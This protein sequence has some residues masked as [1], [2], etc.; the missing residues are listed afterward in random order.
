MK[1]LL[2]L[3]DFV[4]RYAVEILGLLA[5]IFFSISFITPSYEYQLKREQRRVESALHKRQKQIEAYAL[6]ALQQAPDEWMSFPDLPDDMVIYKYNADTLQ[7]WANVFPI[8]NDEINVYPF[9]YKLQYLSNNNIY[10]SP[11]AYVDFSERFVNL[12]S[13]WYVINKQVSPSKQTKIITAIRV[14]TEFPLAEK[15]EVTNPH[16][17]FDRGFTAVSVNEDESVVVTGLEGSPLFS[18]SNDNPDALLAY[19]AVL[20]WVALLFAVLA[21][22]I[23]HL[24]SRNWRSFFIMVASIIFIR[25]AAVLLSAGTKG[26]ELFSPMLYSFN[27]AFST[28]GDLLLN[29]IMVALLLYGIFFMRKKIGGSRW[30]GALFVVLAGLLVFYIHYVLESLILNSNLVLEPFRINEISLYMVLCY[31]SFAMLF[32][33]LLLILQMAVDR[34]FPQWGLSLFSWRGIIVFTLAV[35]LFMVM[36]ESR[37]GLEKEYDRN[38]VNTAKLAASRDLTLEM[39]LRSVEKEIAS[40]PFIALLSTANGTELIKSRL[41]DRYFNTSLLQKYNITISLCGP[42]TLLN[43]GAGTEPAPCFSFFS[44]MAQDYGTPLDDDL[45]FFYYINSPSGNSSYL[46]IFTYV[47]PSAN[48]VNRLYLEIEPKYREDLFDVFALQNGGKGGSGVDPRYSYARYSAGRLVNGS[49]SFIYPVVLPDGYEVGYT[50]TVK[51]GYVHFVNRLSD[52]ETTVISRRVQSFLPYVISFSYMAIFFGLLLLA[53]TRRARGYSISRLRDHSLSRRIMLLFTV[54]MVVALAIM[55]ASVAAYAVRVRTTGNRRQ[56]EEKITAVQNALMP[57]CRY[58][59]RLSDLRT[60]E[61][62]STMDKVAEVTNT[63][64]NIYDA[65]GMLLCSTKPEI[66]AQY[67]IGRRMNADAYHNVVHRSDQRY[68]GTEKVG[69][70]SY[71]STYAPLMNERGD[72]VAIANVPYITRAADIRSATSST[73]AMIINI[74]LLLIIAA[75]ALGAFLGNSLVRPLSEIRNKLA[76]LTS[77]DGGDRHISYRGPADELGILVQ[78]YNKMVD[79]LDESTRRLAQSEREQAWKEMARQ[80]AHEIKNPL[81]PMRLSIQH[82]MRI[83]EQNYPGWEEKV[84]SIGA[85]LLEQIDTL[86]DTASEF[87]TIAKSF[88]EEL[89]VVSLD[90]IL[91]EQVTIFDNRDNIEFRYICLPG[92]PMLNVR[93]HQ[94]ARTFLNIL[95]NAV[96]SIE[97]AAGSGTVEITVSDALINGSGAYRVDIEDSGPG[98]SEENLAKLFTPNFTTKSSGTGLG[99]AICKSII[100]QSGG[101][102]SYHRSDKLGGACFTVL[103]PAYVNLDGAAGEVEVAS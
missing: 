54:T 60:P 58:T 41:M 18:L 95:T 66:F 57:M 77:S 100:E 93:R 26:G 22:F 89:S 1:Y 23:M 2:A 6:K 51:N 53:A 56:M 84:T 4:S 50:K 11:L 17:R 74:Y 99:L 38:R 5:I 31:F 55:V 92:A 39:H 7:S 32:L 44:S 45:P 47:D 73:I 67:V 68:F 48:D 28:L 72:L 35:S 33:A 40:D 96:Q 70:F 87:S 24:R 80:V 59:M 64:I 36:E 94:M 81:T 90:D 21:V 29:N 85:S 49:G 71:I 37:H 88:N 42:A 82:L 43:L 63:D 10:N 102:I 76:H 16:L 62:I 69:D 15:R 8:G 91:K 103:L 46:G 25:L 3:R 12:G 27:N 19:A 75:V 61:F 78:S 98:V 79:D 9:T 20:K 83:K 65:K 34:L 52:Y 101:T 13:D 86:S 97:G 30:H 14:K